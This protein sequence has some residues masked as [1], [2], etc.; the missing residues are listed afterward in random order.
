[1]F[2]NLQGRLN[3]IFQNLKRRGKLNEEDVTA[4]LRQVRMALLEAD[5]NLKV[6]KEFVNRVKAK[7]VGEEVLKSLTPAQQVIKIVKDE[8]IELMGSTSSKITMADSPPT[9]IMMVGLHGSGKTTSSGKL[10]NYFRSQGH[11]PLLVATD[12]YRPAAINSLKLWEDNLTFRYSS[13]ETRLHPQT[14]PGLQ[15]SMPARI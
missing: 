14:S 3:E 4:A 13:L 8:L 5:V 10:A 6:V 7:A 2:D 12:V 1:M 15:S 11:H 9:V